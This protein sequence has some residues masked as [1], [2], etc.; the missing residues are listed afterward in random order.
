[1]LQHRFLV[2]PR[3]ASGYVW[4]LAISTSHCLCQRCWPPS[5]LVAIACTSW[6]IGTL[7]LLV[8]LAL[9]PGAM[10]WW[11]L[12][13]GAWGSPE[14]QALLLLGGEEECGGRGARVK[15]FSTLSWVVRYTGTTTVGRGRGDGVVGSSVMEGWGCKSPYCCCLVPCGCGHCCGQEAR[16]L[17]STSPVAAGFSRAVSSAA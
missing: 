11:A 6:V 1:M 16:V 2:S 9:P 5:T 4:E 14:S 8:S 12:L 17:C 10:G 13:D 3:A 7:Q 15:G